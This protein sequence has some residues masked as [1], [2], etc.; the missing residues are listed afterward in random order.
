MSAYRTAGALDDAGSPLGDRAFFRVDSR[1]EPEQLEPGTLASSLNGRMEKRSWQPRR[2]ISNLS[3]AL[4]VDGDPLRIPFFLV[5]T[6]GGLAIDSASRTGTTVTLEI[7]GHP[8][9]PGDVAWLKVDGLTGS[10]DPNGLHLIEVQD[11]LNLTYE[12]VGTVGS[13]TYAGSGLVLNELDD[14]AAAAIW[15]SCVYSDPESLNAESIILAATGVAYKVDTADGTVTEIGYP[16]GLTLDGPVDLVQGFGSVRLRRDGARAW[17]WIQGASDFTEVA[18]GVYSQPQVFLVTGTNV[19]VVAG[20]CTLT[21][22]GN[23]TV[24]AGDMGRIYGSTDPHFEPFI[25]R[26]YKVTAA[27]ATAISF[28]IPVEDLSTI[29]ANTLSFGKEVSQGLG[30]IHEP[31]APWGIYHQRR[32]WV[33]YFYSPVAGPA[34]TDRD[35]RDEIVGSDILDPDTFDA[36]LNQFRVTAGVADHLIAMHAFADDRLLVF[37]RNSIHAIDGVSGSL[38]D[39]TTRELTREVGCLA[40]KSIA[41]YASQV[42]FLADDGVR[43]IGFGDEYN[44]RPIGEALSAPIQPAID[45]INATL[46]PFSVGVYFSRRYW[47]AV[48]LDSSPGAG[49]ATGNNALLVYNFENGGWESVDSVNDPR[50]LVLNLHISAAG[51]RNDLYAVND[52]GGVHKV[53]ALDDDADTL[54]LTPGEALERIPVASEARTR[55]YDGDSP[56]RKRFT[57]FQVQA[58]SAGQS[59]DADFSFETEN[60]MNSGSMGSMSSS[61]E[62]LLGPRESKSYRPRVGGY[63]GHGISLV[64][65]PT[66]G[67]PKLKGVAVEATDTNRSTTN[68]K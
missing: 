65:E 40:R 50:W 35:L 37:M 42:L 48:P 59:S 11:V 31:G 5:D 29:A 7:A 13:E 23:T 36:G 15:G 30:F 1:L 17:D 60:P 4:Q 27:T 3:G 16:T 44:L 43:A 19:D 38:A 54:A 61:N 62:G 22:V 66:A 25:G 34:Y 9:T 32:W 18:A 53:D 33:P 68:Q 41:Q 51:A 58:E 45:R 6:P 56:E 14:G 64:F 49:D 20:L 46:A 12:L 52:L 21:V 2:A 8:F 67:R 39:C 55:Q 10:E 26:E 57:R 47:L 24:A 63:R 28:Y